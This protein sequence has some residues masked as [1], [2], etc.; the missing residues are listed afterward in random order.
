MQR[1]RVEAVV[2]VWARVADRTR[3]WRTLLSGETDEGLCAR[4][5]GELMRRLGA[6]NVFDP[7]SPDG[8]YE[9]D[10]SVGDDR[11]VA[12]MLLQL[13]RAETAAAT[14]EMAA[15]MAQAQ[16]AAEAV[17]AAAEAA[18]SAGE[19]AGEG[20]G[21][22]PGD[23]VATEPARAPPLEPCQWPQA[24]VCLHACVPASAPARVC[25]C[26]CACVHAFSHMHACA[27][28]AACMGR[29]CVLQHV[30]HLLHG[31]YRNRDRQHAPWHSQAKPRS[32]RHR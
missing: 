4:E 25:G 3:L 12:E 19:G 30:V 32:H 27:C 2:A 13:G 17:Q 23:S 29:F 5:V 31:V 6:L 8:V 18:R 26:I 22:A 10:I 16:A 28:I 9:L 21:A 11:T 24:V 1:Y 20:E 15:T 14:A 7:L